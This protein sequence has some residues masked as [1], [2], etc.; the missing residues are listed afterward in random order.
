MQEEKNSPPAV[1]PPDLLQ[2]IKDGRHF[3][4]TSGQ[5]IKIIDSLTGALVAV[6]LKGAPTNTRLMAHTNND[7]T[8]T[9]IQEYL[10]LTITGGSPELLFNPLIIDQMC[11]RII[12]GEALTSIC[13][14]P[15]FPSYNMLRRWA[16]HHPWIDE[17]LDRARVDRAEHFR[18]RAIMEA[19]LATAKDPVAASSLRVETYKWAAGI[20]NSKYSPKAKV[21][22]N[23]A[24]PTQIIIQ[25]GVPERS[26][27]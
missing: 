15:G 9:W 16:R 24:M 2:L 23:I 8:T 19:S 7:G 11:T 27:D 25:T 10:P 5:Q 26:D 3:T 4:E 1:Q 6:L 14:S 17:A 22:A 21:E 12:E 13:Q 18:D 20:D